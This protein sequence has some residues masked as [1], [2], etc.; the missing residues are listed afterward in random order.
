MEVVDGFREGKFREYRK[1]L[2][3]FVKVIFFIMKVKV[4]DEDGFLSEKE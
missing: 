3:D 2:L 4:N 1:S